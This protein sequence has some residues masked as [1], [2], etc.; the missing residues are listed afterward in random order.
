M[1]PMHVLML[2]VELLCKVL[3]GMLLADI[4]N[5]TR[6]CSH[7]RAISL[8]CREIWANAEDAQDIPF[9]LGETIGSVE[10]IVL[11]RRACRAALLRQKWKEPIILPVRSSRPTLT[12][13]PTWSQWI[14]TTR[15]GFPSPEWCYLLPGGQSFLIGKSWAV[16][17][18]DLLGRHGHEFEPNGTVLAVDWISMA[19]GASLTVGLLLCPD[20]VGCSP[21]RCLVLYDLQTEVSVR[22]SSPSWNYIGYAAFHPS[23][24]LRAALLLTTSETR[25]LAIVDNIQDLL[26]V[27]DGVQ[28]PQLIPEALGTVSTS[29]SIHR[30]HLRNPPLF[31]LRVDGD[32]LA[33][34]DIL[35]FSRTATTSIEHPT[36]STTL[37]PAIPPGYKHFWPCS[38]P[39]GKLFMFVLRNSRVDLYQ[40][41]PG[42]AK[43]LGSL[44]QM[45]TEFIT[46][47]RHAPYLSVA[48]DPIQGTLLL[49]GD[50]HVLVVQY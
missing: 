4:L 22:L 44:D 32:N 23:L 18:Y 41:L 46:G 24:P 13:I 29:I 30:P 1:K 21:K 15:L 28:P 20:R 35:A 48:F 47:F 11:P 39:C 10:S 38:T 25:T 6:T 43:R 17:I 42:G 31:A 9:P 34:V 5:A 40:Y 26:V 45:A 8:Q 2:P 16:G 7:L 27:D 36:P 3:E 19:N 33:V 12:N 49:E 37:E 50:G 14:T